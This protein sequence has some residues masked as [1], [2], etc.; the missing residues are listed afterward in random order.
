M[1]DAPAMG[2]FLGADAPSNWG[3]WGPDDEV[4]CLNYLDASQV[5]RGVQH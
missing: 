1:S 5:L 4:G 3:K 2:E